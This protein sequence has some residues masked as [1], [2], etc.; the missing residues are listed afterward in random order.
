[1]ST[2]HSIVFWCLRHVH[3]F[4]PNEPPYT[5]QRSYL[6]LKPVPGQKS[7]RI[8]DLGGRQSTLIL[9]LTSKEA[10]LDL[11][12]LDALLEATF[13]ST[14]IRIV[15]P[16]TAVNIAIDREF[17]SKGDSIRVPGISLM[18]GMSPGET[19]IRI[20]KYGVRVDFQLPDMSIRAQTDYTRRQWLISLQP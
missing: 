9:C 19:S 11:S 14:T 5:S 10:S 1:M 12:C 2:I 7:S 6:R 18:D 20:L 3:P 17:G 16:D 13:Q 8:A 15:G 4:N